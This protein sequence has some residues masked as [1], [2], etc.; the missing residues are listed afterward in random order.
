MS[1]EKPLSKK[2]LFEILAA[3]EPG[4]TMEPIGGYDTGVYFKFNGKATV[5]LGSK[6]R[7]G[8]RIVRD[9]GFCSESTEMSRVERFGMGGMRYGIARFQERCDARQTRYAG[10]LAEYAAVAGRK[11]PTEEV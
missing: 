10:W 9:H 8:D 5:P 4:V 2:R 3:F 6:G 1:R 11:Q 7:I